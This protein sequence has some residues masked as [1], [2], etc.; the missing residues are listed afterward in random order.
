M[1]IG[2]AVRSAS[3]AQSGFTLLELLAALIVF[4]ASI[5]VLLAIFSS[6]AQKASD[7]QMQDRIASEVE[8]HF[9][10]IGSDLALAPGDSTGT[11]PSGARWQ[12]TIKP[13]LL[14]KSRADGLQIV[15]YELI[16]NVTWGNGRDERRS[17]VSTLKFGRHQKE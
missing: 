14:G 6:G 10:R 17:Q 13:Y 16:I 11:Y 8:S 12:M 9:D 2:S 5:S 1:L 15:L 3:K 7:A 4:G